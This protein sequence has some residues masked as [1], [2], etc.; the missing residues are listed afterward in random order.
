M[1][2]SLDVQDAGSPCL[3]DSRLTPPGAGLQ[4]LPAF[5]ATP[6]A[7]WALIPRIEKTSIS[8]TLSPFA[9]KNAPFHAI[10]HRLTARITVST[11]AAL[12][13]LPTHPEHAHG[14]D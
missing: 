6:N 9:L 8:G 2:P 5:T 10:T 11:R 3:P 13:R 1:I 14:L 7:S 4:L 12:E